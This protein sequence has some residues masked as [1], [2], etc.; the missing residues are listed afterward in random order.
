MYEGVQPDS[1]FDPSGGGG[2]QYVSLLENMDALVLPAG[3]NRHA[4]RKAVEVFFAVSF[5]RIS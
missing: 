4:V 5:Y 3:R 2:L 1:K